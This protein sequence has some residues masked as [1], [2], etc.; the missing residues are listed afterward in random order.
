MPTADIVSLFV[1]LLTEL[2]P[3]TLIAPEFKAESV[4]LITPPEELVIS[5]RLVFS[6]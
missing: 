6:T 4:T 5:V 2:L 1:M 3:L